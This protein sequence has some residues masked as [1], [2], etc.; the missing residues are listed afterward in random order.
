MEQ[1][2]SQQDALSVTRKNML[3]Y[4]NTHDVKYLNEDA[5]FT[6]LS[7]GE[8]YTGRAEIGGMLHY[9]YQVA[10][11]ATADIKSKIVTEDKAVVE[12][13]FTGTHIA[14]FAGIPPTN[15]KVNVP[16]C[17]TY[18]LENGLIKEARIYMLV[19][20]LISQLTNS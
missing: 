16:L 17:V 3:D 19:N 20:V 10:F 2:T 7:T 5:V 11:D 12:G 6:N 8:K 9:F 14:E 13:F 18:D 15:K 1:I 4:F